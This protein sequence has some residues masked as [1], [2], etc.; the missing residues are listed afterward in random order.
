MT[1][2]FVNAPPAG[3]PKVNQHQQSTEAASV[4]TLEFQVLPAL[5]GGKIPAMPFRVVAAYPQDTA[6]HHMGLG[7]LATRAVV[8]VK[9]GRCSFGAKM[10]FVPSAAWTLSLL[11]RVADNL[12][13]QS[14]PAGRRGGDAAVEHG[15]I[16]HPAHDREE[17]DRGVAYLGGNV[18]GWHGDDDLD[19]LTVFT[20]SHRSPCPLSLRSISMSNG[21]TI[22]D[23]LERS[24]N[25]PCLINVADTR[26]YS[27]DA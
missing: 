15:R 22:N 25:L 1:F 23:I 18:R 3:S 5:F 27:D 8:L 20:P 2:W 4:A 17:G 16:A 6:C 21:T 24:K 13:L 12:V 26:N 11:A 9:R 14:C 19:M 7:I 10:R